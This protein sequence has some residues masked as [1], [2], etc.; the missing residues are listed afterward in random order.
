[1]LLA[2]PI[3][4]E[5]L[6]EHEPRRRGSQP[7]GWKLHRGNDPS[8]GHV[9]E[10][11]WAGPCRPTG[12]AVTEAATAARDGRPPKH[13]PEFRFAKQETW[14]EPAVTTRTA[15]ANYGKA[16]T[17]AWDRVHPRLTHRA[18]WLEH[19]GELPLIGAG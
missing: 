15:T 9:D 5:V 8:L 19:G 3:D 1:M 17:K 16:V 11:A 14:P 18:A 10:P 4:L 13:G 12:D 6:I 2:K 7:R